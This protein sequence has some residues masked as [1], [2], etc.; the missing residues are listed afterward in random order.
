[1]SIT[2]SQTFRPT[3]RA[4]TEPR[5]TEFATVCLFSLLGLTLTVAVVSGISPAII[6]LMF[7][8]L[9]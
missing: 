6:G 4:S 3:P 8:P 9:G 1:M 2:L 5:V 7:A